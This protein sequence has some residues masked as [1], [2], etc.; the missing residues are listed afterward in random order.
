ML[1]KANIFWSNKTE[2]KHK[3]IIFFWV[4]FYKTK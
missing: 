2:T 3:G 1:K 4:L